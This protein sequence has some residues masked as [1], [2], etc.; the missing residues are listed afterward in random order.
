MADPAEELVA[1]Q[2]WLRRLAR[3]LVRSTAEADDL[4]QDTCVTALAKASPGTE[5]RPWL[6]GV[7]RRLALHRVRS[8]RRRERREET[9]QQE[10]SSFSE[11]ERF[12]DHGID[13]ERLLELVEALPEPFRS[14]IA[15]R[16]VAGLSCADIARAQGI[17]AG[18]VR[19]RLSRALELLRIEIEAG[20]PRSTRHHAGHLWPLWPLAGLDDKLAPARWGRRLSWL[21]AAAALAV[22]IGLGLQAGTSLPDGGGRAPGHIDEARFLSYRYISSAT[23]SLP[24]RRGE[25]SPRERPRVH[26]SPSAPLSAAAPVRPRARDERLARLVRLEEEYELR[27]Y[28][29]EIDRERVLRCQK[30]AVAGGAGGPPT[31]Q[32]LVR[33]LHAIDLTRQ[34]RARSPHSS[35]FLTAA[36]LTNL[37]VAS[38]L[39]CALVPEKEPALD[40][41]QVWRFG[42]PGS[43]PGSE[44][45]R[46]PSGE[47]PA[48][49][50]HEGADGADCTTCTGANDSG[51]ACGPVDCQ[52]ATGQD[53]AVC[54]SCVDADGRS[55]T[56]CPEE[57]SDCVSVLEEFALLCTTCAGESAPEC[58]VGECL[59]RNRCLECTDAKGRVG[60]DCS[61]D[62][63]LLPTALDSIGG[64]DTMHHCSVSYGFPGGATGVCHY[65]GAD[66]CRVAGGCVECAYPDGSGSGT[67]VADPVDPLPDVMAGRPSTL[68]PPGTCVTETSQGGL[69]QCTTCTRFDLSAMKA[70]RFPPAASCS[71]T[72][73][74]NP[75]ELC[76]TCSLVGG[77]TAMMCD[78]AGR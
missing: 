30:A 46:E 57:Q 28:D 66:T 62:Y 59:V 1:H 7:M 9:F 69:A 34:K 22:A 58:L 24:A 23:E 8:E 36:M 71:T 14:T 77:G 78:D 16:F 49:V 56:I 6:G 39:G 18:T 25:A 12:A 74:G 51:T 73:G 37:A 35:S 68:P 60:T 31:C 10:T 26:R 72:G 11:P 2:H 19:W 20:K 63:E 15:D 48:C 70:C 5:M 47:E 43:E 50:A 40:L 38:R 21:A 45:G 61:I 53:G 52:P 29:C 76:I 67:C 64:G 55:E 65:P 75:I 13:R 42:Q 3:R 27:L 32:L 54:T 17:P 44:P 33:S 41:A 4:V